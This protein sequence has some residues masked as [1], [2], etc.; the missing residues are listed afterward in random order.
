MSVASRYV[1]RELVAIFVVTLLMLLLVAVGGR[2]ISYLQEAALGKFTG[3]TVLTIIYLRLPE[4]VQIVAPFAMYVAVVLTL[5]RL[6][7][8]QEM[9]VLQSAGAGLKKVLQWL[10]VPVIGITLIIAALTLHLTPL[11][12]RALVDFMAAERAQ[13]EFETV[14]AGIFH[15]YD[16]GRRVTYS[17]RMSDD[18]KELQQV[19]MAQRLEDGRTV[20]V[21]ADKGT[22]ELDEATGDQFLVLSEGVR[23]EGTPGMPDFRM[24]DFAEL[25]QRLN[26]T[27]GVESLDVEAIPTLELGADPESTGEFHWRVAIPL[28]CFIGALLGVGISR[29]KP[30]QG[31]FAKVVPGMVLMLLY[32]LALLLNRNG[33]E[34]GNL[35][36]SVGYWFVHLVFLGLALGL[37][38]RLNQPVNA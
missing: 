36:M 34:E 23:Y 13:T 12:Q 15:T 7:A 16:R 28:F 24:V 29:V 38:R 22:Q 35:P 27:E 11:S 31:R 3:M 26:V 18:R 33:L 19:F 8:D 4:F 14:N 9:V 10:S 25:K 1:N 6:Y 2:F 20:T 5:G 37:L 30:R 32:Y 17:E 21:W